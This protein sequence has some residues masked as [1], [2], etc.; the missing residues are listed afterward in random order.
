MASRISGHIEATLNRCLRRSLHPTLSRNRRVARRRFCG[1]DTGIRSFDSRRFGRIWFV[2]LDGANVLDP[3]HLP[4]NALPPPV[5]VEE[6]IADRQ[7]YDVMSKRVT[8]A[9]WV[10]SMHICERFGSNAAG[11]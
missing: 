3:R 11:T 4:F 1:F 2:G 10:T 9:R 8:P 7:T 6:I 5:H